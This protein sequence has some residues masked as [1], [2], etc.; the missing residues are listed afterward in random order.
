[1]KNGEVWLDTSGN[2]IHAHGGGILKVGEYYYWYGENRLNNI[3][4]S[5]YRSVDFRNW[6]F[7]N[8]ILTTES[9][10]VSNDAN[11]NISLVNDNGNKI[12]IERP[13]I[14]FNTT[15]NKFVLW[16]HY[17]NGDNYLD[18]KCCV[19]TCDKIDGDY[20]Y[21]GSFN[22]LGEMSRDCTLYEENGEAYFISAARDNKDLH[23]Y[24]LTNDYLNIDSQINILW[25]SKSREA[26]I[27]FKRKGTYYLMTSACTGWTPNQGKYGTSDTLN[28][29]F[30]KLIKIG[31][32]KTYYSQSFNTI[33][34]N[35]EQYYLGDRW[36]K[37]NYNKSTYVFLKFSFDVDGK[38]LLNYT[39]D[40]E[41]N[42]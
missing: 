29:Q 24:K 7:C 14:L 25:T 38:L 33:E 3:F 39:D 18:A 2:P 26:P 1:M 11:R 19:A 37:K 41:I 8:N 17:E 23:I 32:K 40:V 5:I 13:K 10:C 6:E 35:G 20:I 27:L 22:P 36:C 31:D 34:I 16:G 4:A 15:I 28:G 9:K 12:L 42:F 30:T 21:H